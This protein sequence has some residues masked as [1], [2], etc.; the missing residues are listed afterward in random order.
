MEGDSTVRAVVS[1]NKARRV[2]GMENCIL[3][4]LS[5][6]LKCGVGINI[7]REEK[8]PTGGL[9]GKIKVSKE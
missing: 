6:G 3:I 9:L 5:L 4:I 1:A 7:Y 8:C 2:A